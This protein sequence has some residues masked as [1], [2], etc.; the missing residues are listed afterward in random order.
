LVVH[1]LLS[2]I[3]VAA[4][5]LLVMNVL[6]WRS[7]ERIVFQPSAPPYPDD[8]GRTR[9]AYTAS[10][11]Q[12]L[13]AYV[14]GDRATATGAMLVFHG[15]AD[16]A[17]NQLGWADALARRTG[18]LVVVP[19]YRGYAGLGGTPTYEGSRR[20]A[21]AAYAAVRVTLGVAE[22]QVTLFGHSL[23]SAIATELATEVRPRALVLQ[24]PFTSVRAMGAYLLTP[25]VPAIWKLIARVHW[26]TEARVAE[27]DAPVWVAHGARD[28]VIPVRM[29]QA[30]HAAARHRG[31]L[32]VVPGA[33]HNDVAEAGGAAYARWLDAALGRGARREGASRR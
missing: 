4:L 13:F 30:V 12:P 14:V 26:D 31:E 5:V 32:L 2:V 8:R 23:G 17:V 11:G 19:E 15:N 3:A 25:R 33:G 10:D 21:R 29:G 27:L 9:V 28:V 16:L 7:Q 18:V 24:S 6:V 20:D 1:F 22:G